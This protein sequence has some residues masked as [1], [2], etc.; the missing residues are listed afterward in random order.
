MQL[1]N[2]H[3]FLNLCDNFQFHMISYRRFVV[4]FIFHRCLPES[5]ITT[6]PSVPCM[7][8]SCWWNYHTA[9]AVSSSTTLACLKYVSDK[10]EFAPPSKIQAKNWQKTISIE[11]KS[12]IIC[13]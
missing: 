7:D 8:W 10:H 12:D 13:W 11:E 2:L 9:N 4:A 3:H 5:D 1:E 6:S